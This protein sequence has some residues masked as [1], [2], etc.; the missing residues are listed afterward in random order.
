MVWFGAISAWAIALTAA[1]CLLGCAGGGSTGDALRAGTITA[2][3]GSTVT[4]TVNVN[5]AGTGQGGTGG[6][7]SPTV[8]PTLSVPVSAI[9]GL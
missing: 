9:P 5:L 7:A 3:Q 2:T 6:T 4:Y 8:S 1:A